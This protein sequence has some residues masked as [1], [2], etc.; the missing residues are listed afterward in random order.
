VVIERKLVPPA[1]WLLT[2]ATGVSLTVLAA[3]L[4]AT[5]G[6]NQFF[7][8]GDPRM[9]LLTARDLF[10]TGRG[11]ATIG[12]ESEIPFRYGRMGLPLLGWILA[13]G[14][15]GL[16][17]WTMIG[18]N[19]AALSAI[20]ALMA[21]TLADYDAPPAAAGFVFALPGFLLLYGNVV[22][23]PL[24]IALVLTA[25]LLD[26]RGHLRS[27][28]AVLAYAVLVKE[29]ALLALLPLL[30]RAIRRH[31][32]GECTLI[33]SAAVPYA[34][35]CVWVRVRLG[36]FP[37]VTQTVSRSGALGLPFAGLRSTLAHPPLDAPVILGIF[38]AT[39]VLGGVGAWFARGSAIGGLAALYTCLTLCLGPEALK[40]L[41]ETLRVFLM[42]EVFGLL[43][44]VVGLRVAAVKIGRPEAVETDG[45]FVGVHDL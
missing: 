35:W 17:G 28:V 18:I 30:W 32:R 45:L 16:V 3:M 41:A 39:V 31:G 15:P 26:R 19:L 5:R 10:G 33:A 29:V 21:T 9:F 12:R 1:G 38:A 42:P 34:A 43:A 13:L 7:A 24:V 14:R 23:D 22:S 2:G 27:A 40:F 4:L 36:Q 11:F 8:S 25:Y 44:L 37:F 6:S 20:P